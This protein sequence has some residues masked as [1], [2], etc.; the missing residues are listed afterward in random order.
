MRHR[1]RALTNFDLFKKLAPNHQPIW[2]LQETILSL[3][4]N[5]EEMNFNDPDFRN[6]QLI[7]LKVLAR[8]YESG[9]LNHSLEWI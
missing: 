6:S 3:K 2:N 1:I 8:H 9:F 4:V 7:R 5:L